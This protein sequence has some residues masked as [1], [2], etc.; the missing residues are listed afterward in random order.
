MSK[1]GR[2]VAVADVLPPV[3]AVPVVMSG[4][5]PVGEGVEVW[6]GLPDYKTQ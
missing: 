5:V 3:I 1:T 2:G 4:C 6:V